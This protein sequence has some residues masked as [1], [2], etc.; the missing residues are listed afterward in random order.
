MA[1]PLIGDR[2][3]REDRRRPF[4]AA[5]AALDPVE[6]RLSRCVGSSLRTSRTA[7]TFG[8]W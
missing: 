3:D 6:D 1:P 7:T 8:T 5:L 4:Q 2:I